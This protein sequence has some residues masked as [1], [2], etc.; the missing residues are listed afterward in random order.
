V[1]SP[2]KLKA[3]YI[4]YAQ[5]RASIWSLSRDFSVVFEMIQWITDPLPVRDPD[6]GAAIGLTNRITGSIAQ[7]LKGCNVE[8]DCRADERGAGSSQLIVTSSGVTIW[9]AMEALA[10]ASGRHWKGGAACRRKYFFC[11]ITKFCHVL[12][13]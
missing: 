4:F 2:L 5:R 9:Q 1:R 3:F 8:V 6:L 10:V 7:R 13:R 12:W 11:S